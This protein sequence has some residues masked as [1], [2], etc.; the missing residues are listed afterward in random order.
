MPITTIRF[1]DRLG[2][3]QVPDTPRGL[4]TQRPEPDSLRRE[5]VPVL[6]RPISRVLSRLAP[7]S[8]HSSRPT[9]ARGLERPTRSHCAGSATPVWSCF[10]W[11]LPCPRCHHRGGALL[12]HRFT[13]TCTRQAVCFLWHFPAGRP[14]WPLAS[15]LPYEA[16]TF[17]PRH[18]RGASDHLGLSRTSAGVVPARA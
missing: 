13:L 6:E 2:K 7:G 4:K 8:D 16:R 14:D 9:I 15:T 10:E 1:R 3:C 17:L 18:L 12:P 5:V 11:G